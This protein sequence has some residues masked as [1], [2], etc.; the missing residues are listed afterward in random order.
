MTLSYHPSKLI[1]LRAKGNVWYVQVTKPP[2]LQKGNDK[3]IRRSTGTTDR[4]EA[5]R[6]QHRITEEIYARFDAELERLNPQPEVKFNYVVGPP[7]PLL[8]WRPK[9]VIP[10]QNI[11]LRMSRVWPKYVEGRN[12]GREKTKNG[13]VG[14]LKEFISVVGDL[15]IDQLKKKH[16]Y[17]YA[18]YLDQSGYARSTVGTRVRAVGTMLTWCEEHDLIEDHKLR[19]LRL[20][21]YGYPGRPWK[22]FPT[23]DLEKI[24]SQELPVQERLCMSLLATTGA[25]LD[26]IAL[27]RWHQ[28]KQRDEITYLDLTEAIIKTPGSQR[29][30]PLHRQLLLP[31]PGEDRLFDYPEGQDGKSQNNASRAM[32]PFV[33]SAVGDD[34]RKALHSF[35]GTLKDML[36]NAG[37]SK[38]LNDF[39]TVSVS[40]MAP[41][42]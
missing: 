2:E 12:W 29:F 19:N 37:V 11:S 25:R 35:R 38:E 27:L 18:R 16:G 20:S 33:R 21:D 15:Q 41:A 39:F 10:K 31:E 23:E 4:K 40:W 32:M 42:D 34:D 1:S 8:A 3:Q 28:V 17:Q 7:D 36:R 6:R 13:V 22:P 14:H 26:E 24:F 9:P 5:E 30:V